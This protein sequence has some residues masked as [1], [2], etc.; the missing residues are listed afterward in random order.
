MDLKKKS[1]VQFESDTPI[2]EYQQHDQ[3]SCCFGSLASDFKVP[4]E[5]S[6][7]SKI[8]ACIYALLTEGVHAKPDTIKSK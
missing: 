3:N 6:A 5:L 1:Q 7:T 4:N 2:V 8:K